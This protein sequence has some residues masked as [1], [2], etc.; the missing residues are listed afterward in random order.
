MPLL[1]EASIEEEWTA[2]LAD[3]GIDAGTCRL[4]CLKEA[5][6]PTPGHY[7]PGRTLGPDELID[8]D[9]AEVL[10]R[11]E[12][13][14]RHRIVV[15]RDVPD[16]EHGRALFAAKLRHELEHARQ[17]KVHGDVPQRLSC[18]VDDVIKAVAGGFNEQGRA[19]YRSQ[20]N[21]LDANAAASRFVRARFG[22][23][24]ID[25]I[26]AGN[27]AVLVA[28]GVPEPLETLPARNVT[29]LYEYVDICATLTVGGAS[30]GERLT[31]IAP[32]ALELWRELADPG[33]DS[34]PEA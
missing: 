2:A 25:A 23:A 15:L 19:I 32:E 34:Q 6:G 13:T 24:A 33:S 27:D 7:P 3:A 11:P 14:G 5:D 28:A 12:N 29:F 18:I 26:A 17:W 8:E 16:G 20:P 10:N 31:E 21:E 9:V 30:F 1:D 4:T 22:S